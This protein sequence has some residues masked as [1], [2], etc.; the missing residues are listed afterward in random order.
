LALVLTGI[1]VIRAAPLAHALGNAAG[2]GFL[3]GSLLFCGA[4]YGNH[5]G[6]LH[7]GPVAPF[8]GVLL[9]LAWLLLAASAFAAGPTP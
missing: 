5:L 7:S 6:G 8:G 2:G 1:W 4:I 9:M 3:L